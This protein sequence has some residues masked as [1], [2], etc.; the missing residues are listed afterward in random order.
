MKKINFLFLF[1]III[2][3]QEPQRNCATFKTGKFSYTQEINGKKE[4][5]TFERFDNIQIENY[6]GKQD[7]TSIRWINDCEYIIQ[8]INPKNMLE[9]KALHFKILSTQNN[10]YTFEYSFVGS[11]EK[12]KGVVTKL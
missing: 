7:T 11:S 10:E 5:S 4:V 8:K 1:F 6:K 12:H 9:K 3:C 2:G